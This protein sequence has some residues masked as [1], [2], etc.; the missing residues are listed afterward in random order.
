[1]KGL[2]GLVEPPGDVDQIGL[3]PSFGYS[4]MMLVGGKA[5]VSINK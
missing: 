5:R 1:M 4:V 3:F 2:A